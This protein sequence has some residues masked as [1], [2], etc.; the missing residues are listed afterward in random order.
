METASRKQ[1]GVD[2]MGTRSG[3]GR[4]GS[5]SV[6]R[7][8][9]APFKR[10]KAGVYVSDNGLTVDFHKAGSSLYAKVI[11]TRSGKMVRSLS[12]PLK[13]QRVV[14]AGARKLGSQINFRLPNSAFERASKN[15]KTAERARDM[16]YDAFQ[17]VN[18]P[19]T[20]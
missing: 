9:D 1:I 8:T 2:I 10:Q 19:T 16:L 13:N 15:P 14:L 12:S 18:K 20:W 6:F 5:R 4:S 3:G 7:G 11:H 17:G